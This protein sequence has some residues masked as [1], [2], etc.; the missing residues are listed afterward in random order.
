MITP[1]ARVELGLELTYQ[2]GK[3]HLIDADTHVAGLP[4]HFS[5]TVVEPRRVSECLSTFT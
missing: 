4:V 5:I 2:L 1:R 3:P